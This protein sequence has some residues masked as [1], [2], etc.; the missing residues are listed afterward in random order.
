MIQIYE[1]VLAQIE[2]NRQRLH[3]DRQYTCC[4]W[5]GIP[6]AEHF[7]DDSIEN[8]NKYSLLCPNEFYVKICK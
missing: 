7:W 1:N 2:E 3:H 4:A 6:H 8:G 5:C